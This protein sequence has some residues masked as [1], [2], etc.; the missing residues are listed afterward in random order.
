MNLVV[1]LDERGICR[2]QT[3]EMSGRGPSAAPGRAVGAGQRPRH[4]ETALVCMAVGPRACFPGGPAVSWSFCFLGSSRAPVPRPSLCL[5]AAPSRR[6]SP[7]SAG[8]TVRAPFPW[9]GLSRPRLT[10]VSSTSLLWLVASPG[11]VVPSV[12]RGGNWLRQAAREG[13]GDAG[14]RQESVLPGRLW[15]WVLA[16]VTDM[17]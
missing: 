3:D 9:L 4:R 10:W 17:F 14:T 7:R 13:P 16:V 6:F 11:G 15:L 1:G 8:A 2:G 5:L 12:P